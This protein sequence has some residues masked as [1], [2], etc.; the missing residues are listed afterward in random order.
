MTTALLLIYLAGV[1]ESIAVVCVIALFV[2]AVG[3]LMF[4]IHVCVE[5]DEE[6][7]ELARRCVRRVLPWVIALALT[8]VLMPSKHVMYIASGLVASETVVESDIGQKAYTLLEQRLDEA[9]NDGDD[10]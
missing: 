7:N 8:A 5:N 2:L 10:E 3:G 1:F 4:G 6:T 9:L